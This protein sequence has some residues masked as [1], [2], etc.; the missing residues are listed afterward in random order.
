MLKF[1]HAADVHLDSPLS[2]LDSYEGAPVEAIRGATRKALANL[3]RLAIDKKV[4][5]VI[6]AGDVY[7]GNW[8]DYSTG[9]FFANRMHELKD[10][11]IQVILLA[12]NHDAESQISKQFKLRPL[13]NVHHLATDIPSTVSLDTISVALHGQGF[14][15][16]AETHNLVKNYPRPRSGYFNIGVLHTAINGRENYEPDR[17]CPCTNADLLG[18]G[19]EYWALGHVHNRESVNG[20]NHPRI[21]FPGN[22]QGRHIRETGA[23]GCLLVEVD[24]NLRAKPQFHALDVFRWERIQVEASDLERLA[25]V[26]TRVDEAITEAREQAEGRPLAVRI[27]LTLQPGIYSEISRNPEEFRM[28]LAGFAGRE[29][30]I[31]KIKLKQA[32]VNNEPGFI[33]GD[34]ARSE[35]FTALQALRENAEEEPLADGDCGKLKKILPPELRDVLTDQSDEIW[36]RATALLQAAAGE[37]A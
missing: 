31:E 4:D 3:V 30:W 2:G 14:A 1:L 33:L 27:E 6:L 23:K 10:A 12:G 8:R 26:R 21:E 32:I 7:D 18:C 28:D 20:E 34:D 9:L 17:Y 11:G 25:D 16:Q 5:F 37:E 24:A 13:P 35:L 19:Y 29:V 22:I 15:H 36:E